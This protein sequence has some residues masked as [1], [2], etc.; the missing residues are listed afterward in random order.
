MKITIVTATYNSEKTICDCVKSISSQ[1]YGEIEHI[2]IDGGSCDKTIGLVKS[3]S[4][5]D[6]IVQ[7]ARDDG[8]YDALNKGIR[9]ASGDVI[10]FLHSDDV[11]ADD[12]VISEVAR[13][14]SNPSIS[15]VYGDLEYVSKCDLS[16]VVRSWKSRQFDRRQLYLGW[17][18]PHPTLYLRREVYT[19][20]GDFDKSFKIS[21]DYLS[22]LRAFMFTDIVSKHLPITI[23]K[24]RLGG[25]SNASLKSIAVKSWEDVKALRLCKIPLV[26]AFAIVI[27]KNITKVPQFV[28]WKIFTRFQ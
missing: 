5:K 25:V 18:P 20:I 27:M 17:M 22:I 21:A 1:T 2:V 12:N 10:G 15:A 9:L 3:V 11:L 23:V 14:F 13:A 26:V 7:S 4:R 6:T 24:M 19:K 8:I 28:S 16:C